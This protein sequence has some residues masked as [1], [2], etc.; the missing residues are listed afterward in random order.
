[1]TLQRM[2]RRYQGLFR[3][4]IAHTVSSPEEI[5]D[6]LRHLCEVMSHG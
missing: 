3:E 2:R 6:E 1:M 5:E 4:E